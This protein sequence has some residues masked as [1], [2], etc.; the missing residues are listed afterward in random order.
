MTLEEIILNIIFFL[1]V[2]FIVFLVNYYIFCKDRKNK[3]VIDKQ[4]SIDNYLISRF[5]LNVEVINLKMMN[6]HTS[7]INAFIISFVSTTVTIVNLNLGFQFLISFILLFT[8]IYSIYEI[9]GRH[10]RKKYKKN[11]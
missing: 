7:I 3:K 2:F 6:F 1:V 11:T 10:L 5:K 8:L 9:Y 4:T